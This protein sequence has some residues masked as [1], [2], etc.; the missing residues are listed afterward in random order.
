M[1]EGGWKG[2]GEYEGLGGEDEDEV[3]EGVCVFIFR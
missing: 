2:G 3:G 1:G